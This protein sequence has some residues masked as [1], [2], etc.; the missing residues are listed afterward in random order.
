MNAKAIRI[1]ATIIAFVAINA[2]AAGQSGTTSLPTVAVRDHAALIV[3][4]RNEQLPSHAAVGEVLETNNAN[5]INA[6]RE[7]IVHYAHREC[8]RGAPSV[9]FVRDTSASTP[10]LAMVDTPARQ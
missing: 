6:G 5:S 10:A 1:S 3:D 7:V 4:C 9:A 2:N 8:M